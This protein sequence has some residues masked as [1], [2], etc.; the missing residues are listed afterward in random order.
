M[1]QNK[2][3][4]GP[5]DPIKGLHQIQFEDKSTRILCLDRVKGLLNNTNGFY[6]L[7]IF[8][9]PKLFNRYVRIQEG[10][11]SHRNDL[12]YQFIEQ[13]TQGNGPEVLKGSRLIFL[14]DKCQ[15]CGVK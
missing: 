3:D 7:S 9:K 12:G 8:Q 6:N 14:G 10:L 1:N 15:K 5:I 11:K 2:P 4:E 13:I